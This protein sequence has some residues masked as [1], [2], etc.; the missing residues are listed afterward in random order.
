MT[1]RKLNIDDTQLMQFLLG[2]ASVEQMQQIEKWLHS[3]DENQKQLDQLEAIWAEAGELTPKPVA[4]DIK[5]GWENISARVDDF[6]KLKVQPLGKLR[7]LNQ[8]IIKISYGAAAILILA[9][10]IFKFV[11]QPKIPVDQ[12]SFV[13]SNQVFKGSLPD[14]SEIALN[15]NSKLLY[16]EK[17]KNNDR[18]VELEGEAFFEVAHNPKKPFIISAGDATIKVLGTSFNVKANPNENI[19]VSVSTGKVLLFKIDSICGDTAS[20]FLTAGQKGIVPI[21]GSKPEKLNEKVNPDEMYWMDRTLVFAQI[22][23]SKV[24][25]ILE[26][27]YPV[28]IQI[29]NHMALTCKYTATFSDA[30][31]DD[32]IK[33]I[34]STFNFDVRVENSEYILK[35]NGCL[36]D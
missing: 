28:T 20:I 36:D 29:D 7:R 11:I 17:F 9:F 31:I 14:G 22:E 16:P 10:G 21:A 6:E 23:L 32:I 13:A 24:I 19:E 33:M 12:L 34:A 25:K 18:R 30:D 4:V 15:L 3:S 2:E 5:R 8:K 26:K 35:G 1:N 27:Y